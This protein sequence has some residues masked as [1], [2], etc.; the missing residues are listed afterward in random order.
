MWDT[1]FG[2]IDQ[3]VGYDI[4]CIHKVTVTASSIS[5][6]AQY[7]CLQ[8]AVDTFHGHTHNRLCQFLNHLLFLKGFGL[9]DLATCERIF[10]GINPATDLIQ[11]ALHFYWLQFL[12]LQMDQWDKDKYLELSKCFVIFHHLPI[13]Q[14]TQVNSF[15]TTINRQLQS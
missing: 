6:K 11:H 5:K 10:A 3:A 12:D 8:A 2:R 1:S 9:E 13:I 7:L 14:E 15:S 4:S